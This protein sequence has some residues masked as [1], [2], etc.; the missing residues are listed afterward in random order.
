MDQAQ[1]AAQ[2]APVQGTNVD[3][4]QPMLQERRESEAV[5]DDELAGVDLDAIEAQAA[6]STAVSTIE[7]LSSSESIAV[8][9]EAD[10]EECRTRGRRQGM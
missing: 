10:A 9:P 2:P 5:S 3:K 4:A 6:I 1:D 7:G 8:E